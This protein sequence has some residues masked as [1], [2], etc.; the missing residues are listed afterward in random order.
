MVKIYNYWQKKGVPYATPIHYVFGNVAPSLF[1]TKSFPMLIED[2]YKNFPNSRFVG[3]YQFATPTLII[4]DPELL[5]DIT[6]KDFDSFPDRRQ[7]A[8]ASIDPL[9]GK[10]LI[11]MTSEEGWHNMRSTLTP[12]FTSSKMRMMFNLMEECT[13]QYINYF[14]NE[15]GEVI[16]ELKDTF[17]RFANDIIA[18]CAFGIQCNSLKD[19]DNEFYAMSKDAT[20]FSGIRSLKNFGYEFSSTLMKL[21]DIKMFNNRVSTFFRKIIKDTLNLRRQ[22]NII[23]SDM[24]HLLLESAKKINNLNEEEKMKNFLSELSDED[25]TAQALVFLIA[26]FSTVSTAL[27]FLTYNLAVHPDIQKRVYDEIKQTLEQSP[28]STYESITSMVYLDCVVSE[29]LRVNPAVNI[30]DR[31]CQKSYT[32][33]PVTPTEKPVRLDKGTIIWI[34][35]GAFHKDEKYFPNPKK[36][37]PERFSAENKT[38]INLNAYMPFGIGPRRCIGSRFALLEMK[39]IIVEILKNFEIVPNSKTEIPLKSSTARFSGFPDKGLWLSF[40]PRILN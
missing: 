40:K 33:E 1:R 5:K 10:N 37:D 34:P 2:A 15:N 26:G 7:I 23:R 30:S 38:N 11:Q 17:T 39:T 14:K 4:T 20:N 32:I 21:L 24:I 35:I 31:M 16:L 9:W 13:A 8:P 6:V 22:K 18:T 3:F 25:I 27:S 36:F 28:K 29:S 19:K 12:S